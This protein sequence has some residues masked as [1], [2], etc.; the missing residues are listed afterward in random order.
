[1]NNRTLRN[2]GWILTASLLLGGVTLCFPRTALDSPT[3]TYVAKRL[4][5]GDALYRDVWDIKGPDIYL[6][7][8]AILSLGGE[9]PIGLRVFDLLWQLSTALC[10]ASVAGRVFGGHA[11]RLC[12]VLYLMLYYSVNYWHFGQPDGFLSLPMAAGFLLLLRA[13]ERDESWSWLGSAVMVGVVATF[14]LPMGFFGVCCLWAA[15]RA[16]PSGP[17]PVVRRFALL[18]LGLAI[19]LGTTVVY[20]V[21]RDALHLFL[22]SQF[23]VAPQYAA[24]WRSSQTLACLRERILDPGVGPIYLSAGMVTCSKLRSALCKESWTLP[25]N[26]LLVWAGVALLVLV[27]HGAYFSYQFLP[28]AAPLAILA[29]G[30]VQALRGGWPSLPGMQRAALVALAAAGL[31]VPAYRFADG[32]QYTIRTLRHGPEALPWQGTVDYVRT[33]TSP[34]DPILVWG[35]VPAIYVDSGRRAATRFP[36]ML[37]AARRWQGLDLRAMLLDDLRTSTPAVLV[38]VK[39]RPRP[40]CGVSTTQDEWDLYQEFSELRRLIAESYESE[41]EDANFIVYQRKLNPR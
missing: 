14:K 35:N 26:L 33:H 9:R 20:L 40:T 18:A 24:L 4:L 16:R 7:Y 12:G 21:Q 28:L 15:V 3:F 39:K 32:A 27:A 41:M 1:M 34:D 25:Q 23:S 6:V 31:F 22:A 2:V 38:V 29:A 19:P 30:A 13:I 37:F 11:A 36:Y 8:A 5:S 17:A 10:A